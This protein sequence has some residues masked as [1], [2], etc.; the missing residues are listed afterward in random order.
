MK[1]KKIILEILEAKRL[2]VEAKNDTY[3]LTHKGFINNAE[4]SDGEME[5][6]EDLSA[7]LN[8]ENLAILIGNIVYTAYI[9]D[10]DG[11]TE[12]AGIKIRKLT[13]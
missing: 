13:D 5:V 11:G 4:L 12:L 9:A 3:I 6:L 7:D 8:K 1:I 2:V 10:Y